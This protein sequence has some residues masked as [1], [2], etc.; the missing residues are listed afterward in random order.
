MTSD[1]PSWALLDEV[2]QRQVYRAAGFRE[3]LG[4][5][6][7]TPVCRGPLFRPGLRIHHAPLCPPAGVRDYV[8]LL[9]DYFPAL[10]P[11]AS[12]VTCK[13][14]CSYLE[15]AAAPFHVSGTH[16]LLWEAIREVPL[17][18]G[19]LSEVLVPFTARVLGDL[20]QA[21]EAWGRFGRVLVVNQDLE[22]LFP[23][24][25]AGQE[26][27]LDG[28]IA[29][30]DKA[31]PAQNEAVRQGITRRLAVANAGRVALTLW[32]GALRQRLRLLDQETQETRT[33]LTP[34][35]SSWTL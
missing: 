32:R 31:L 8:D 7:V 35:N 13:W 30:L 33:S 22:L 25:L 28:P 6:N 10:V 29:S 27:L 24:E 1:V 14:A 34:Q 19:P 17:D 20:A 4:L 9:R 15:E 26:G 16:P 5:S 3:D 12:R 11:V 2:T 21:L 23:R 18:A